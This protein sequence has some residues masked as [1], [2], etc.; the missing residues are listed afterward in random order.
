MV[1]N[2]EWGGGGVVLVCVLLVALLELLDVLLQFLMEFIEA[3]HKLLCS[4]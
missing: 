4:D 3:G 2:F 1:A